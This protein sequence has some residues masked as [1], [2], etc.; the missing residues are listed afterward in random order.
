MAVGEPA[1][2][3]P[4]TITSYPVFME[5]RPLCVCDGDAEL[6]VEP[7]AAVGL[8]ELLQCGGGGG[9]QDRFEAGVVDGGAGR[10]GG[11]MCEVS[12]HR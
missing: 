1:Q 5:L 9:V 3:A 4:T 6:V 2:R 7:D 12:G 8:Y 10:P 11:V